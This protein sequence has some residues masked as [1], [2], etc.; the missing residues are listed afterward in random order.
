[1]HRIV[2]DDVRIRARRSVSRRRWRHPGTPRHRADQGRSAARATSTCCSATGPVSCSAAAHA[3]WSTPGDGE[4]V[5]VA[6]AAVT[7][8]VD[9]IGSLVTLEFEGG[10]G[11][12]AGALVGP[13][14][15]GRLPRRRAPGVPARRP[16]RHPARAAARRPARRR[17][18]LRVRPA[19]PGRGAR[20]C[21]PHQHEVRHLLGMAGRGHDDD[22]GARRP[23]RAR[24]HRPE[25]AGDPRTRPRRP[26]RLAHDRRPT[27][28]VR[29]AAAGWSTCSTRATTWSVSA[30][31]RDTH[32]DPTGTETI[33]HE[34]ALTATV[35]ADHGRVHLVQR[36]ATRAAV[37]GVPGG[38]RQRRS[39]RRPA[40][41]GRP[42]LRAVVVAR[43][44]HVHPPERPA[45]LARR[46]RHARGGQRCT[47]LTQL[48]GRL[49]ARMVTPASDDRRSTA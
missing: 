48:V 20:R 7:A 49:R 1:M 8:G 17:T 25:G 19:L 43:H 5:V 32:V 40:G 34:Y 38:S 29:C 12:D 23:R 14:R 2:D 31:F 30:L 33:L 9:A 15:V 42:R 18:D 10:A 24:H 6:E 26:A 41:G 21:R 36:R 11:G 3:T 35:D 4:P 27:R 45:A 13:G 37:G 47:C 16:R 44:L 39:P 46:R 22:R 28:R